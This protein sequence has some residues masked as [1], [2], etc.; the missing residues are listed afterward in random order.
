MD[1]QERLKLL[2][3]MFCGK[4]RLALKEIEEQVDFIQAVGLEYLIVG[5]TKGS[6][7]VYSLSDFEYVKRLETEEH[8]VYDVAT[9]PDL[10]LLAIGCDGGHLYIFNMQSLDLEGMI[11]TQKNDIVSMIFVNNS[12]LVVGQGNGFLDVL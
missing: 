10:E 11:E 6:V 2:Q 3:P 1:V 9:T 4:E 12:Q 8:S 7:Y 5:S